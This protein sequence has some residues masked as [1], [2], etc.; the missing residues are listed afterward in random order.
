[1]NKKNISPL[2]NHVFSLAENPIWSAEK[3]GIF[4]IDIDNCRIHFIKDQGSELTT[5]QLTETIGCM[6]LATDGNTIVGLR[7]GIYHFNLITE[8][9]TFIT[10][11]L[12][13]ADNQLRYN[14]GKV[15]PQGD[16]W[17]ASMDESPD[18]R[19]LASLFCLT[20]AGDCLTIQTGLRV[21]NG[22][23]FDET[24]DRVYFSD[25]RA[26]RIYFG[27]YNDALEQTTNSKQYQF[28]T[29][30]IATDEIGRPDGATVDSQGNYW[31]AGVS[32]GNINQ[33]SPN[34][35]LLST[36][37]MP[38]DNPTMPCFIGPKLDRMAVTSLKKN[39]SSNSS[40]GRL[41]TMQNDETGIDN[42]LFDL[43]FNL[44]QNRIPTP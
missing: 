25:T 7:S 18:R 41:F 33:F 31:S 21:G 8:K 40:D 35:N 27:N 43:S 32:A 42:V 36:L 2:S 28:E 34:G 11:P 29:F 20:S 30:F 3:G 6:A 4:F 24:R 16:F 13:G 19:P 14:D 1:M 37:R 22:I 39:E 23:A 12:A 44:Y 9:L 15:S 17:F 10:H 5:W 38:C 26:P